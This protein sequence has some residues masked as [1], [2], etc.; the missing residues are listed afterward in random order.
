MQK[1]KKGGSAASCG[2]HDDI[3]ACRMRIE[4][5]D[6]GEYRQLG[7]PVTSAMKSLTATVNSTLDSIIYDGTWADHVGKVENLGLVSKDD[8]SQNYVGLPEDTTQLVL[9]VSSKKLRAPKAEGIPYDK[10]QR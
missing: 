4:P 2:V 3:S 8:M 10:G 9:A 7:L 5:G 6:D 1:C